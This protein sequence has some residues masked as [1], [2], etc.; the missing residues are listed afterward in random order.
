DFNENKLNLILKNL[1]KTNYFEDVKINITNNILNVLVSENPIIQSIEIKGIK[2]KKLRDPILESLSLKR[3][4]S[5]TE[6]AA[7]KDRNLLLNILKNSGFYFAEV[8]LKKIENSNKT[9]SLIYDVELGERAKIKKI[10]FIGDKKFKDRKLFRIIASE[11]NK[12]WKFISDKKLL[13]QGRINLDKKLLEGF[14]RNKG[15]YNVKVESSFAQLLDNGKFDLV[16]NINAGEKFF[17]NDLKLIIPTDYDRKNFLRIESI[18]ENLKN[19][20]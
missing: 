16:F 17:F 9:V 10:L 14:Y 4:N 5:F 2:A 7:R 11:E 18:L 13:N 6:F 19:K 1:Y 3:N 20:P 8:K 15:Y 12:F